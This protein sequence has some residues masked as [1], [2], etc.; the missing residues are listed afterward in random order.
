MTDHPTFKNKPPGEP[1]LGG[2]HRADGWAYW[3][4]ARWYP[5]DVW[6]SLLDDLGNDHCVILFEVTS[7]SK[8]SAR[9]K[10]ILSPDG[11]EKLKQFL[12]KRSN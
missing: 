1:L 6:N 10:L 5:Q 7:L 4:S 8:N 2:T 12:K 11:W 9:G 3:D